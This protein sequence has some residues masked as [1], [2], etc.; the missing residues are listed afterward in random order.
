VIVDDMVVLCYGRNDRKTPRLHGIRLG[1]SGDVTASNR[2]WSRTDTGSF[3]PSAAVYRGRVY[4]VRDRGEVECIDP[5]TG[6]T[7]WS[8]AFPKGRASYYAS[9]TIAGGNLYA[10]RE[11][12]MVFVA[13][14][15][16]GRF[17]LLAENDMDEPIIGSP[18]PASNCIFIRGEDHLF[19][20]ASSAD[21][22]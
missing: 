7:I 14:V 13:D 19:C 1:G 12:G 5:A 17:R 22:R 4:L 18:V 21:G 10:A 2:V 15:T 6:K 16:N 3:V 20:F 8:E 9:P 11:D